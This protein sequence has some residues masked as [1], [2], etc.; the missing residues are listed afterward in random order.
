[1][2][3]P[4]NLPWLVLILAPLLAA[5]ASAVL[6]LALSRNAI[7]CLR[8]VDHPNERSLHRRPV[9]RTGGVALIFGTAS[10]MALM[11]ALMPPSAALTWPRWRPRCCS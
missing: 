8:I 5:A 2:P 1:M 4:A 11:L 10:G 3:S 6:T 7:A 9:P